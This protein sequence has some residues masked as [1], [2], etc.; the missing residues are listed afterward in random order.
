M[1]RRTRLVI[2]VCVAIII[3]AVVVGVALVIINPPWSSDLRVLVGGAIGGVGSAL[4]LAV[5]LWRQKR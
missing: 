4:I 2:T 1:N 3:W 5:G